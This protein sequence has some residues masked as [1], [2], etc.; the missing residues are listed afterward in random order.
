MVQRTAELTFFPFFCRF[1]ITPLEMSAS[2][3]LHNCG[4]SLRCS[5]THS[6]GSP[7]L[8]VNAKIP[9]IYFNLRL[10][11]FSLEL[12]A[13]FGTTR[14]F[15]AF[16]HVT[17]TFALWLATLGFQKVSYMK[18]TFI[19]DTFLTF[20]CTLIRVHHTGHI[21]F[22]HFPTTHL[23]GFL[24]LKPAGS[25]EGRAWLDRVCLEEPM[26][27]F[28]NPA[29]LVNTLTHTHMATLESSNLKFYFNPDIVILILMALYF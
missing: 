17:K 20:I 22:E 19:C 21:S 3:G 18:V 29:D 16:L 27:E 4:A 10:F 8:S 1:L 11:H 15:L 9:K 23:T 6:P 7:C 12:F 24:P 26:Y 25:S 13:V 2:S 14:A 28:S 5:G